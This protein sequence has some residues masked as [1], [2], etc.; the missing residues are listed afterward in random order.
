MSSD[1]FAAV[2]FIHAR[3]IIGCT[4]LSL[5]LS[6]YLFILLAVCLLAGWGLVVTPVLCCCCGLVAGGGTG[7]GDLGAGE[8]LTAHNNTMLL[9]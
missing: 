4:S 8:G 7:D 6:Q 5:S 2:N 9:L 1:R 3:I